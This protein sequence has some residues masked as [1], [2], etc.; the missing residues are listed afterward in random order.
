LAAVEERE[1]IV[2]ERILV[3]KLSFRAHF[4]NVR[5]E[6]LVALNELRS[7]LRGA[8]TIKRDRGHA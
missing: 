3:G 2:K 1:D 8:T 6:A 7:P 4:E 5:F